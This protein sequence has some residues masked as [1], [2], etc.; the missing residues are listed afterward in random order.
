MTMPHWN[1]FLLKLPFPP[2]RP[3]HQFWT[4]GERS[5]HWGLSS[6]K[7]LPSCNHC[8]PQKSRVNGE[9]GWHQA[10][11]WETHCGWQIVPE[12][13]HFFLGKPL[14]AFQLREEAGWELVLV[15]STGGVLHC[16]LSGQELK[17]AGWGL[18]PFQYV[19]EMSPLFPLFSFNSTHSGNSHLQP[20]QRSVLNRTFSS[21]LFSFNDNNNNNKNSNIHLNPH[22]SR[23]S[24]LPQFSSQSKQL[25]PSLLSAHHWINNNTLCF[26]LTLRGLSLLCWLYPALLMWVCRAPAFPSPPALVLLHPCAEWQ[27][28]GLHYESGALLETGVIPGSCW[29]VWIEDSVQRANMSLWHH[30]LNLGD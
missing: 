2:A 26:Q 23:F 22:R 8:T 10:M 24:F 21:S 20:Q 12:N 19:C 9:G 30:W 3:A 11:R 25:S 7:H 4:D 6:A 14:W 28:R 17:K 29:C 16:C 27:L 1:T 15:L 18:P 13:R 5:S